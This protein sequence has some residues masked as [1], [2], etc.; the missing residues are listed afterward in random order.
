MTFQGILGSFIESDFEAGLPSRIET[1]NQFLYVGNSITGDSSGDFLNTGKNSSLK[2][3]NAIFVRDEHFL[4]EE[5]GAWTF[6]ICPFGMGDGRAQLLG[7]RN[8]PGDTLGERP[9]DRFTDKR[10]VQLFLLD[11]SECLFER[12]GSNAFGRLDAGSIENHL[13]CLLVGRQ[14]AHSFVNGKIA[15]VAEDGSVTV[16]QFQDWRAALLDDPDLYIKLDGLFKEGLKASMLDV[17][18]VF[19]DG[20]TGRVINEAV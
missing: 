4:D 2:Y 6:A 1:L 18:D 11:K 13:G 16:L 9:V 10:V 14:I 17:L 19:F 5:A 15:L 7:R 12:C 8:I 3:E 20:H